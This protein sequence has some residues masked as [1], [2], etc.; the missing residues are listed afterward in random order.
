MFRILTGICLF[1]TFVKS[2]DEHNPRFRRSIYES[3]RNKQSKILEENQDFWLQDG[4]N[5]I[6]LSLKKT[7][8]TNIAK[9]III[10]IG[11][12]MSLPTVAA[13]RIFKGQQVKR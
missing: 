4:E 8:N 7:P 1:F 3:G 10:F 9:N 5:E 6:K 2:H 13:A 11:D 12:C